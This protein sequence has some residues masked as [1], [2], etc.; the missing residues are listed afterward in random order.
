MSIDEE[1]TEETRRLRVTFSVALSYLLL[2]EVFGYQEPIHFRL[3]FDTQISR[4]KNDL[5]TLP[6]VLLRACLSSVA[7]TNAPFAIDTI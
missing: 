3:E 7:S 1:R 5:H 6:D 4:E 2:H